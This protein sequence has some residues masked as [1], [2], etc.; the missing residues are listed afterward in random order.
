M[1]ALRATIAIKSFTVTTISKGNWLIRFCGVSSLKDLAKQ[2]LESQ[3]TA[4]NSGL[5]TSIGKARSPQL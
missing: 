2:R 4:A 1:G 3:I 5:I